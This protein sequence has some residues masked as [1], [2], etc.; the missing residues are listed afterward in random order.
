VTYVAT[1]VT[2]GKIAK[3]AR[4]GEFW[5]FAEVVF[6]AAVM[7]KGD[8]TKAAIVDDGAWVRLNVP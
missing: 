6:S 3:T 5:N 7:K 1:K 2:K 8:V 4:F